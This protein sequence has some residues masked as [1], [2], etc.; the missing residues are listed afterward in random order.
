MGLNSTMTSMLLFIISI[1]TIAVSS[2]S[3][4]YVNNC[5]TWKEGAPSEK[6]RSDN[7][8]FTIATLICGILGV[9]GTIAFWGSSKTQA[10]RAKMAF[11]AL[12]TRG[13]PG[14]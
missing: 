7:K 1:L 13:M 6:R 14:M 4:Q 3:I 11:N 9:V 10:G 12:T 5:A 8:K 2:I